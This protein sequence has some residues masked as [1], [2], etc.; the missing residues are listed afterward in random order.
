MD[1][2]ILLTEK[3]QDLM[4]FKLGV[5]QQEGVKSQETQKAPNIW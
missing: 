3:H 4:C 1:N 2:R 5:F